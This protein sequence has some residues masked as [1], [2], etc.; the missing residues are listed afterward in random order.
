MNEPEQNKTIDYWINKCPLFRDYLGIYHNVEIKPRPSYTLCE[1]DDYIIF[2]KFVLLGENKTR[3]SYGCHKSMD[4]QM[5][6]FKRYEN[7]ISKAFGTKGL[8]VYY[9]YAH[10]D[11][12]RTHIEYKG[13]K[14]ED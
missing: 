3:D 1:I 13:T 6:R 4:K 7:H 5:K 10:F 11:N 2:D 8:P 9:F 14:N 12:K